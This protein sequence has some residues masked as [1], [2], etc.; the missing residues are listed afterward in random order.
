MRRFSTALCLAVM[1][2]ACCFGPA[3]A[4]A[5]RNNQIEIAYVEPTNAEFEP[6]YTGLKA[7]KVLEE[8]QAFLAPLKLQRKILV[9]VDQCGQAIHLYRPGEPV[10]IC[11][12]Y[13]DML[14]KLAA[15]IP[16]DS[17]TARGVTRNDAIV[18]AFVQ[19]VLQQM[20]SAVFDA[21]NT[22]IWGREQDAADKL[23]GFLMLQFGSDT[24]RK[25]LTGAAYFFEASDRTW[26]G[27]DF[28][29]VR[30]TE[31]Q[32]F[33]NYLCM[34]Y[35]FNPRIFGDFA[36]GSGSTRSRHRTD[37]LPQSRAKLC[38]KEYNDLKWAF[39]SLILPNID[40]TL[41]QQVL[42][43]QWLQPID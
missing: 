17:A 4:E 43:R 5:P 42:A 40:Q 38:G 6:Y 26:T 32:R 23:A 3:A 18:G 22:P 36:E 11:Y 13:V 24:A 10:V 37:V 29:D 12:E 30:G 35:G 41:L 39:D 28:S 9:K 31:A 15:K 2:L 34:A 8:L 27:S 19:A 7:R 16:A 21:L 25:L 14:Q 20:A 1:A 33:Y